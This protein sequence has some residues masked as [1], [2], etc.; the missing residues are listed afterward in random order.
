MGCIMGGEGISLKTS[1]DAHAELHLHLQAARHVS[2]S[3]VH[4]VCVSK[5]KTEKP[6]KPETLV[7][8]C[9][10]LSVYL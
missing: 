3:A 7:P 2:I 9:M 10:W 4:A 8:T 5:Q 1:I 6:H